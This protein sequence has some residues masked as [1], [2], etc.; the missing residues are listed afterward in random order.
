MSLKAAHLRTACCVGIAA[1]TGFLLTPA[2]TASAAT[3]TPTPAASAPAAAFGKSTPT[4]ATPA[5][6]T[7]VTP[8][9]PKPTPT[10]ETPASVADE[11]TL[12]R[13]EHL[14]GNVSVKVYR[15]G[16]QDIWYSATILEDT[17]ALGTLRAGGAYSA[18]DRGVFGPVEVTLY[19]DGKITWASVVGGGGQGPVFPVRCVVTVEK[20]VGAGVAAEMTIA[21]PGPSVTFKNEG[22]H[23][24]VGQLDRQHPKLPESAGFIG[25]ILNPDS[26]HPQLF[27]NMEGG[28]SKG[29][30]LDFPA[31]PQGCSFLY[32]VSSGSSEVSGSSGASVTGASKQQTTVVPRGSVA[33]GIEES[34]QQGDRTLAGVTGGVGAAAVATGLGL[35]VRRRRASVTVER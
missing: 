35:A 12:V 4:P 28:G 23:K 11:G 29:S 24:V 5:P 32:P 22:D 2:V 31:L 21:P 16:D 7:P 6:A 30:V 9:K 1:L 33:A 25:E 19:S 17:R 8:A 14:M 20:S 18:E 27:T 10:T 13:T 34:G 3:A 15:H 26:A